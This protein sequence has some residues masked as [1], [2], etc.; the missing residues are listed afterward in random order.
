MNQAHRPDGPVC[1]PEAA[2]PTSVII[3]LMA[4]TFLAPLDSSIVN[5]ALPAI[6]EHFDATLTAVSWVAT[7]Y[8]L[9][10]A[11][12]VLT[13]GRLGDIQG[14]KKVYMAGFAVFAVG[15]LVCALAWSLPALIAARVVQAVG[16]SMMFATGPALV[17]RTF[18]P[19]RRGWALGWLSL[20][21]SAGL[22]L[23]PVLGGFLL[24]AFGWQSIF[25]INIPLAVAVIVAARRMLPDDC[26]EPEPFDIWGAITAGAALS[27]LLLGMSQIDSQGL[28][29]GFV[30]GA[31]A[32]SIVLAALFI[33]IESRTSHP[34]VDLTLFRSKRFAAGI[35]APVLTYMAL[36]A[37]TFTMPFYLLS[38]RGIEPAIA[39]LIL[40]STAA[41]MA[42]FAPLAG[43]LSDRV[44]S[45]GLA[46]VGLVWMSISLAAMSFLQTDTSLWVVVALLFSLGVGVSSFMTPNSAAVLRATPRARVGVGSALIGEARSVGM[47][48]GIGVTAAVIASGLAGA[49]L[50]DSTGALSPADAELF[51]SAMGPAFMVAAAISLVAAA[52]SWAR[53]PDTVEGRDTVA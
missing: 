14:L 51:V 50:L 18:A 52:I 13:M 8:L 23:G 32:T 4:G 28:G 21:V 41:A 31:F 16:A 48:L 15:S 53:G 35:A 33:W 1:T 22:I 24:S 3:L 19:N 17:T 5:I 42:I 37:V 2:N 46:T 38:A 12:L 27:A 25:L 7:A 34:M 44:G 26:P 40:T 45:R 49:D 29:S 47:A 39:G 30:L 6:A 11:S 10:N 9:T 43:R 20:S 36:F